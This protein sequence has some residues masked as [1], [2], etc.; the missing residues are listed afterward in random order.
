[1]NNMIGCCGL[2]CEKC[3]AY[4]A[5]VNNDDEMRQKTARLWS[6]WNN[7]EIVNRG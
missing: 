2:N 3:G 4:I 7:T 6:E 1:M 5:T